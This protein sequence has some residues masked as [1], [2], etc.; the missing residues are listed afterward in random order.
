MVQT[1]N[2]CHYWGFRDTPLEIVGQLFILEIV[3]QLFILKTSK[4]CNWI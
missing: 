4:A 1:Q 3:G 2:S